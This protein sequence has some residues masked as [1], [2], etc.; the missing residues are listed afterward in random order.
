MYLAQRSMFFMLAS[1]TM[2]S[3]V[4]EVPRLF[5]IGARLVF[6]MEHALMAAWVYLDK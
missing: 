3:H 6:R 4:A 1:L 5:L 2:S